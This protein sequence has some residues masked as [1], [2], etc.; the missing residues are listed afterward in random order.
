MSRQFPG[1]EVTFYRRS[2]MITHVS[3]VLLTRK[4][5]DTLFANSY[6]HASEDALLGYNPGPG[7]LKGVDGQELITQTRTKLQTTSGGIEENLWPYCNDEISTRYYNSS[8]GYKYAP[9]HMNQSAIG[10]YWETVGENYPPYTAGS[11]TASSTW[12]YASTYPPPLRIYLHI[13]EVFL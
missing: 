9:Y 6:Y 8:C 10:N 11:D 4:D 2:I 3:A 7:L 12:R 1:Q 5:W 13:E